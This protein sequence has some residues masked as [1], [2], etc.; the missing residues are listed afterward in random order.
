MDGKSPGVVSLEYEHYRLMAEA[1]GISKSTLQRWF[2]LFGLKPH[3]SDTF[4]LSSDPFF[5]EKVRDVTGLYLNPPDNAMVRKRRPNSTFISSWTTYA[6]HKHPEVG[7]W[8]AKRP[9]FHL[10]LDDAP[11]LRLAPPPSARLHIARSRLLLRLRHLR[12]CSLDWR[13]PPRCPIP[14][15]HV[16]SIPTIREGGTHRLSIFNWV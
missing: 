6:T 9:R 4:K 14:I 16:R 13:A 1:E 3:L 8:L 10:L 7:A 5:I 2:S 12:S 11:S 15:T